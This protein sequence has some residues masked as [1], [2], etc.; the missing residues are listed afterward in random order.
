MIDRISRPR[1]KPIPAGDLDGRIITATVEKR[2]SQYHDKGV[3]EALVLSVAVKD[4]DGRTR[5]LEYAPTLTW[6]PKGK[7]YP[8]LVD[9]DVLPEPDED[10]CLSVFLG[11]PVTVT[12]EAKEYNGEVFNNIVRLQRAAVSPVVTKTITPHRADIE[13]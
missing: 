1:F 9:L 10:L 7:L 5:Q 3:R 4:P 2:P 12:I 8:M 11:M 13:L 6:S